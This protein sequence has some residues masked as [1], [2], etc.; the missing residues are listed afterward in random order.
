MRLVLQKMRTR[1]PGGNVLICW[2]RLWSFSCALDRVRVRVGVGVGVGVR[3]GVRVRGEWRGGAVRVSGE[4]DGEGA[5]SL[6]RI[7]TDEDALLHVLVG[8]ELLVRRA[9]GHLHRVALE[10]AGHLSHLARP[11]RRVHER[12]VAA[13]YVVHDLADLRLEAHVEH[14][15]GLV[16]HHVV[17]PVEP[18]LAASGSGFGSGFGPG[19][20]D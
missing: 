6:L 7:V 15:V 16:H 10:V 4:G 13:R 3:V 14:A 12:L 2:M 20:V 17:D 1:E 9:D 8:G 5:G 18:H 19:G 11:R